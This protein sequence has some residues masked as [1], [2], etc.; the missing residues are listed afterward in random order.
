MTERD[1]T[2][3]PASGRQPRSRNPLALL[4]DT[5]GNVWFGI[6]MMVGIL[7][8]CWLASAGLEPFIHWLPR[9]D[10][11]MTEM[12]VF[13]WWPLRLLVGLLCLS[14]T[15]V[16]IRRIKFNLPNLGVWSVHTGII[17]L[18]LGSVVYFGLKLEGDV[19]VFRRQVL[20][21]V[22]GGESV[23]LPLQPGAP[24]LRLRAKTS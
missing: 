8:Y 23:A 18:V 10:L 13:A 19:P 4:L 5:I 17:V 6:S 20:M 22:E 14:L 7:V 24:L 21:S 3:L 9:H 12:E 15:I 11:E 1:T 16:T 2:T